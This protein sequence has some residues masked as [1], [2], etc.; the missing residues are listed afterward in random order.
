MRHESRG[1]R[2]CALL[3]R[4]LLQIVPRH[5]LVY[6]ELQSLSLTNVPES[7]A[8]GEVFY[9]KCLIAKKWSFNDIEAFLWYI[10]I[11]LN[12]WY[13]NSLP[14]S[15]KLKIEW[16]A[17]KETFSFCSWEQLFKF[18]LKKKRQNLQ[19][20]WSFPNWNKILQPAHNQTS[21]SAKVN[22]F[23]QIVQSAEVHK[24]VFISI[25]MLFQ[26]YWWT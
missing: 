23:F 18:I 11:S 2:R 9:W 16:T 4:F 21:Q 12:F 5:E 14:N 13:L 3:P 17:L 20:T 1:R 22:F 10:S 19:P 24:E 25:P 7:S 8:W 15:K 26:E 6:T